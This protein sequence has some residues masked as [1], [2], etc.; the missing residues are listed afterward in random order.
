M[1][2][3]HVI[4]DLPPLHVAGAE[5]Y[6]AGLVGE[7]ASRS[8]VA[9]EFLCAEYDPST[10]HGTLRHRSLDGIRVNELVNNW[11]FASLEESVAPR[12]FNEQLG[13]V[14]DRKFDLLHLHSLVGLSLDLPRLALDRG[15]PSVA[16]LHDYSLFCAAGGQLLPHLDAGLAGEAGP[17]KA[18]DPER[19]ARCFSG[20]PLG[21][22]LGLGRTTR[23]GGLQTAARAAGLMRRLVPAGF[24]PAGRVLSFLGRG[25]VTP[26]QI[27]RRLERAQDAARLIKRFVAPSRA[28]AQRVIQL[29]VPAAAVEVSDYGFP[30]MATP[31]RT[32]G[33]GKGQGPLRLGYVGSLVPH[34]GADLLLQ[35]MRELP[36]GAAELQVH[37]DPGVYPEYSARLRDMARGLPVRFA[38]PFTP[39]EAPAVYAGFDCLVVTS[40]WPENSPLVI[41]EAFQAGIPVV[42]PELGGCA[43]LVRHGVSGLHYE[44]GSAAD[45]ARQLRCL[46]QRPELLRDLA[47]G[48]PEVKGLDTD[49][50]QWLERYRAVL[51]A[52]PGPEAGAPVSTAT[53]APAP[54]VSIL[55]LTRDGAA[56]LP[57]VLAALDAQESDQRV[58]RVALDSGSTDGT[59]Q[60]LRAA[61]F[62]V[63]PVSPG[64]FQ[65]GRTRNLGI[66]SCRG[67]L[68]A[69][70]VQDAVPLGSGWLRALTAPLLADPNLAGSFARQVPRQ[71]ADPLTCF[72][73]R[74]HHAASRTARRIFLPPGQADLEQL[75]PHQRLELCAFDN[76]CSCVRRQVWE[77]H[78]FPEEPFAEDLAWARRVLLEGHGL[79]YA[80]TAVVE[81]SHQRPVSYELRRAYLAHR[82]LRRLFGLRTVPTAAHLQA[83]MAGTVGS[84]LLTLA[85]NPVQAGRH[86]P[87]ALALGVALPLGQYLG[88]LSA[89]TGVQLRNAGGV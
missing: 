30:P 72:Y 53:E 57:R 25:A 64:D 31:R 77:R 52:R 79:A 66:T 59:V 84:H 40:R 75:S 69:L 28:M 38:G 2:I 70:L 43:E 26:G 82:Q 5:I 62:A 32:H 74:Q 4:H 83:A 63:H 56:T 85:G 23:G 55:L 81:H 51:E 54:D 3:L 34:K 29:G 17:C 42:T 15:I 6:A 21:K 46:I 9:A 60:L 14:L 58:E 89:D 16:T 12:A 50:D 7:L 19:C 18:V 45:L 67:P 11:T 20:S 87:R 10:P 48:V 24:G 76:V 37:G 65:H 36:D 1:R 73:A 41:H 49:A 44:A 8:G 35:A 88:A 68:V 39:G 86:L 71:D 61:G 27:S 13:Q 33:V 78:P 22:L 47:D 80:P